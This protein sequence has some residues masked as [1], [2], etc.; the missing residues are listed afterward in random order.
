MNSNRGTT[1]PFF[2]VLVT[3]T[4]IPGHSYDNQKLWVDVMFSQ[5]RDVILLTLE[6]QEPSAGQ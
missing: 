2:L 4:T 6:R 3:C 5:L 1:Q